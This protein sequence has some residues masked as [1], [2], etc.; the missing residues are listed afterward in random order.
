MTYESEFGAYEH[1]GVIKTFVHRLNS[2]SPASVVVVSYS[3][4]LYK[5]KNTVLKVFIPILSQFNL[6]KMPE[7]RNIKQDEPTRLA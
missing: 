6:V 1:I 4:F 2:L 3:S 5:V 7:L